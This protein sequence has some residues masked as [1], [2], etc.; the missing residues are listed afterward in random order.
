MAP[1]SLARAFNYYLQSLHLCPLFILALFTSI[2]PN[3][4]N[5]CEYIQKGIYLQQMGG[6]ENEL[7]ILRKIFHIDNLKNQAFFLR[8]IVKLI[9]YGISCYYHIFPVFDI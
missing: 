8:K 6:K 2:S 5:C 1:L 9:L 4:N 7:V 3:D